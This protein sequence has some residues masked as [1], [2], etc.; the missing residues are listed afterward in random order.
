MENF[1]KID[2]WLLKLINGINIEPLNIFMAGI[3][4]KQTWYSLYVCIILGFIAKF[5]KLSWWPILGI[6]V[7]VGISDRICSGLLKP[8]VARLRPCHTPGLQNELVKLV[9]CVGLFSFCSSHAAL[10]FAIA[11][12]VVRWNKDS[13]PLKLLYIWAAFIAISRV[14]L[15]VH[16]P[17]DIV[18]G[19]FIGI[20][21]SEMCFS[22]QKRV[23][24]NIF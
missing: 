5:K 10:S 12:S 9:D 24:P 6:V 20:M 15:G 1:L 4:E 3:S 14:Y 11:H 7:S 16:Y 21:V 22:I 8:W 13:Y 19:A 18:A 17:S 2:I 23:K